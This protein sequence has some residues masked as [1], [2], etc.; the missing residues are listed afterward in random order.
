[1][2][3]GD[4]GSPAPGVELRLADDGS[5]EVQLR[6]P[7]VFRGYV[8]PADN[9]GAFDDDWF[10]TGDTG[11][12]HDGRLRI[13]GRLKEIANRN[14]RKVSLAEVEEAFRSVAP[15]TGCAAFAV[16]D[17]VTGERVAVAV[18][19][20]R[21][22]GARRARRARRHGELPAIAKWKLPESV[23]RY[24]SDA[25][26]DGHRQGEAERAVGGPRRRDLARAAARDYGS[27]MNSVSTTCVSNSASSSRSG[28][29]GD[30]GVRDANAARTPWPETRDHTTMASTQPKAPS[31]NGARA[32]SCWATTPTRSAP[33]GRPAWSPASHRAVARARNDGSISSW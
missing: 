25:A 24:P 33:A 23:L 16:P 10:R 28:D 15:V 32:P 14:G 30:T 17:D 2:R 11:V 27:L 26:D 18:Q 4:D 22:R 31:T 9:A 7:H 20:A 21:R 1:M 19:R 3:L 13:V 29:T 8:D 5:D 12:L 6:G